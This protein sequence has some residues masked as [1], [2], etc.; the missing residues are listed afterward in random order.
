MDILIIE[1][2]IVIGAAELSS[3][4]FVLIGIISVPYGSTSRSRC[5]L[6]KKQPKA[7]FSN[8]VIKIQTDR[9]CL[10]F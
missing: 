7:A 1:H 9:L 10:I 5:F 4:P 6:S 2:Y 3:P 8:F